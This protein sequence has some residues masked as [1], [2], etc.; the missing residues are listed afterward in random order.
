MR[1]C[2]RQR[3][4][5]GEDRGSRHPIAAPFRLGDEVDRP[6]EILLGHFERCL[7]RQMPPRS[8]VARLIGVSRRFRKPA[9]EIFVYGFVHR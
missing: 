4:R 9:F 8:G 5:P 7:R 3:R 1:E 6:R 2:G